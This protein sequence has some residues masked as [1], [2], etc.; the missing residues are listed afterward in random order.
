MTPLTPPVI[1]LDRPQMPE[2]IGAVARVMANFSLSELR[3]VAPRD[4][5]PDVPEP[6]PAYGAPPHD[7]TERTPFDR[8]WASSSGAHEI[9]RSAKVFATVADAIM[10]LQTVYATTA[11]NRETQLPVFNPRQA[12]KLAYDQS[13]A[14]QRIGILFGA[15]RAGLETLD[16]A[17]C[18]AIVT[19][20]VSP[21]FH[22]L[23]LSQAVG[24]VAYEW[25]QLILDAPP[26]AFTDYLSAPAPL[27]SLHRLYGHL[28]DELD[29]GG[30]FFPLEKRDSMIRNLRV[31]L[32]KARLTE[33]EVRTFRGIITAL[34]K[35]RGR[36][37]EKMAARASK[38]HSE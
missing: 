1:I 15:E 24:V 26:A 22:S 33:Q 32:N 17:L 19:I 35:G 36:V 5:W 12:T 38:T 4:G 37:L 20:P 8:A 13:H 7:K 3:L 10:D 14:G 31:M 27:E 30:F 18:Q 25:R 6:T 23:N 11:R 28:E 21:D 29:K 2:N 34:V 16:V 9:L